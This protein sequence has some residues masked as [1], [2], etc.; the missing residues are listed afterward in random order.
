M[1]RVMT[2][3]HIAAVGSVV[4]D[5]AEKFAIRSHRGAQGVEDLVQEGWLH[6][7][8]AYQSYWVKCP[9]QSVKGLRGWVYR[10]VYVRVSMYM[11]KTGIP[12]S[13]PKKAIP[14]QVRYGRV[15]GTRLLSEDHPDWQSGGV[16]TDRCG[17]E[18]EYARTQR[19]DAV[20]VAMGRVLMDY[21]LAR[22]PLKQALSVRV[23]A[24]LLGK[25]ELLPELRRQT[26]EARK[27]LRRELEPYREPYRKT[28]NDC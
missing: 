15:R 26:A 10:V 7:L 24:K 4:R 2:A 5:I 18:E 21:P 1:A 11:W 14:P 6:A 12:V 20:D 9:E 8:P 22:L 3:I 13:I 19:R 28:F 27:A 17:I 25:P 23:A 16:D